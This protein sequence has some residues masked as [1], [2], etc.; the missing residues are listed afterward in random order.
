[1]SRPRIWLVEYIPEAVADL[2]A[3]QA[4][5]ER[6]GVLNVVDKLVA[7]G[8]NLVPPHMKSLKGE[9]N[10]MELRPRQ[11]N[12]PVRPLYARVETGFK[13]LAVAASKDDFDSAVDR[14]RARVGLYD[15]PVAK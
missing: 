14:A 4:R 11:G 10:L 6:I 13:I 15:L 7:L 8:P 5:K 3:I 12:S 2:Q 1:M 9:A